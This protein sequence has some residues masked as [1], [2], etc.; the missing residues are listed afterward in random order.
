MR[1]C[2]RLLLGALALASF[3]GCEGSDG[4]YAWAMFM[5]PSGEPNRALGVDGLIQVGRVFESYNVDLGVAIPD[6]EYSQSVAIAADDAGRL[7]MASV[8]RLT[9]E[10]S[11]IVWLLDQDG[12]LATSFDDDGAWDLAIVPYP[13]QEPD[14]RR[15][16]NTGPAH[17][18]GASGVWLRERGTESG[19]FVAAWVHSCVE[20]LSGTQKVTTAAFDENGVQSA[21]AMPLPGGV[22]RS[23][24]IGIA[25]I[26]TST[27]AAQYV[28]QGKLAP[29]VS[30]VDNPG[31]PIGWLVLTDGLIGNPFEVFPIAAASGEPDRVAVADRGIA[32]YDSGAP[33][34]PDDWT[35][36]NAVFARDIHGIPPDDPIH[37]SPRIFDGVRHESSGDFFVATY[38]AGAALIGRFDSALQPVAGYGTGGV[39]SFADPDGLVTKPRRIA[40]DDAG[41]VH[42]VGCSRSVD[43]TVSRV[44]PHLFYARL[45]TDGALEVFNRVR[46]VVGG[47]GRDVIETME[48]TVSPGPSPTV[49]IGGRLARPADRGVRPADC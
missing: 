6:D 24:R 14:C 26:G 9:P 8:L 7:Y 2:P 13:E 21:H 45:G 10:G 1:L 34:P 16:G 46:D 18:A 30:L 20:P 42:V 19:R 44:I 37:V 31:A 49:A 29:Y 25:D 35:L 17:W 27:L 23:A 40:V 48:I 12:T 38:N 15:L 5:E 41:R 11:A 22:E 3:A 39:A 28:I 47:A 33:T 43:A 4:R 32:L 36:V